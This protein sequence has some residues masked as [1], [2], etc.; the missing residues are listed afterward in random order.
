VGHL[1]R[2]LTPGSRRIIHLYTNECVRM[3]LAV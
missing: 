3:S 1:A 2:G